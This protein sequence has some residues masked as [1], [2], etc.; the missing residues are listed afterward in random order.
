MSKDRIPS[1]QNGAFFTICFGSFS[2]ISPALSF[3]LIS[4]HLTCFSDLIL[5]NPCV[6]AAS[7]WH[8]QLKD[9]GFLDAKKENEWTVPKIILVGTQMDRDTA[10]NVTEEADRVAQEIGAAMFIPTSAFMP[11]EHGGVSRLFDEAVRAAM[12]KDAGH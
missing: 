11:L 10:D 12:Y 5:R 9:G 1:L 3:Y 2:L 4:P 6:P 7:K 8:K